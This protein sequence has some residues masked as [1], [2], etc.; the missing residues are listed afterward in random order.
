M[1]E[2]S[3]RRGGRGS[4]TVV[5]TGIDAVTQLTPAARAAIE[6]SDEVLYL[7]GDSV[8]ALRIVSLNDHARSLDHLYGPDKDRRQTYAEIADSIVDAVVGGADVCAVFYG[9]PGVFA[10]PGH[11]AIARVRRAGLPARMLPAVSALDCLVADLGLDPGDT[12]LQSYEATH[13]LLHEP[14]VDPQAMLVLWQVGMIGETGGAATPAVVA[15]FRKLVERLRDECGPER[16]ALLYEA[17]PY[18]GGRPAVALFRLGDG[19]LPAPSPVSTL[20]VPARTA[21]PI[22]VGP[23]G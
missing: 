2:A 17:S 10:Y 7:V 18:P 22:D 5:G 4:L 20:C 9:H 15:R 16:Q 12:G 1:A 21:A 13:F 3:A 19:D 14:P 6:T 23:E 8:S 11:E